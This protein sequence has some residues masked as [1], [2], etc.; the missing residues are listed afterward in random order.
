MTVKQYEDPVQ[1]LNECLLQIQK[2]K[3]TY[4]D[5]LS[6]IDGAISDLYH[7]IERDES[8]DLYKGWLYTKRLKQL[9]SARRQLKEQN[10]RI[11]MLEKNFNI[12][13]SLDSMGRV[14]LKTEREMPKKRATRENDILAENKI[15]LKNGWKI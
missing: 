12:K 6:I 14:M 5:D 2:Q 10:E 7:D 8:I 11:R 9:H 1:I 3:R 15:Q 4:S 13:S